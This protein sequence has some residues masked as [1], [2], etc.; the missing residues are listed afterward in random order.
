MGPGVRRATL[1]VEPPAFF[2]VSLPPEQAV[3]AKTLMWRLVDKSARIRFI[4][5]SSE[6][7]TIGCPNVDSAR[8]DTTRL[9]YGRAI[10][11]VA[12]MDAKMIGW[13]R[14]SVSKARHDDIHH[15]LE[16]IMRIEL[17]AQKAL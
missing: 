3:N 12:S 1:R 15:P 6:Y 8:L 7:A 10:C 14:L 11:A 5:L 13:C 2:G 9:F 4:F 16:V 17:N